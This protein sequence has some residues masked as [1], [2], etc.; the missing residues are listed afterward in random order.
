MC[1][2]ML[3]SRYLKY[4]FVE[5]TVHL[6]TFTLKCV[7]K[8]KLLTVAF[9]RTALRKNQL[10]TKHSTLRNVL[11]LVRY[12]LYG[13]KSMAKFDMLTKLY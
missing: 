3:K 13:I 6:M 9:K 10:C 11:H 4:N 5:V 12:I 2:H 8:L 1:L 7:A